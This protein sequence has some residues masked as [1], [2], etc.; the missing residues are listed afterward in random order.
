M[1]ARNYWSDD[2]LVR[3]VVYQR[4]RKA[5][6]HDRFLSGM[7]VAAGWANNCKLR[8]E[9]SEDVLVRRIEELLKR[10]RR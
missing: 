5:Y 2:A 1:S 4:S 7:R 10:V 9:A 8:A 3:D 6:W